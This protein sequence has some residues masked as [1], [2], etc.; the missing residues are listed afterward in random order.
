MTENHFARLWA[1]GYRRLVPIV[2]VDA[3]LSE[4]SSLYRRLN[5]KNPTDERGKAPG[6]RWPDG[7]WS[8][9]DFVKC[10]SDE[11]DIERWAAMGAGV[12]IKTGAGLALIDADTLDEK[13]AKT[14]LE[15]IKTRCGDLPVRVGRY[16]KAGYLVRTDE[17][18]RYCRI[19]FG[20]RDEKGRLKD[21]VEILSDGRQF[22]AHGIHPVTRK[23]YRW[24]KG[25]PAL[26][27]VPFVPAATLHALL[28]D[29]AS[30]L[31]SAS[32]MREEGAATDVNQAALRGEWDLIVK[33]VE[34][35][36][37]TSDLFPTRDAW[38]DYGYAIKAAAGPDRE[39]DALA[40]F[41]DWSEKWSDGE[42]DPEY[43]AAEFGRF[44]APFKRGVGWLCEL[45]TEHGQGFSSAER[46]F[47][48]VS[49][50]P[51]LFPEGAPNA[52]GKSGKRFTFEDFY[53]AADAALAQSSRPL[54]KGLLDHGAMSVVYGQSN[55]GKT[56]VVMD[57]AYCIAAALPYAGMKTDP[58]LVV[59]VSA[60]GGNNIKKRMAALCVKHGRSANV[61]LRL[62]NSSIDLRRPDADLRP[63][64]ESIRAL[65]EPVALIVIDTLSRAM[66]G[67]DENSPVDMGLI[68]RHF[69]ALRTHT[70]AHLMVVHHSGKNQAAGARGHSILKAAVDTE[71][72]V[73]EGEIEVTKQRDLDKAW[74]TGF[75][76]DVHVLG[77]DGDGD[78]VTSCTVRMVRRE[79]AQV[80]KA[81]EKERA[82]GA[83]LRTLQGLSEDAG[84][85]VSVPE[86]VAYLG[87][88]ADNMSAS[89]VRTLLSGMLRKGLVQIVRR[90]RYLSVCEDLSGRLSGTIFD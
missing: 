57:L 69:D 46:W 34:A 67:G 26:D 62:L 16:P 5:A 60:E 35:T 45:A 59:Y 84:E 39:A 49:D 85:G 40:L 80:A 43:V 24:P 31:P 32:P 22:V 30:V 73:S 13:H 58:G 41:Q 61:R 88:K 68:V 29:L 25:V 53:P 63:L 15:A 76:L 10:E 27:D 87:P 72:E 9:F 20:E 66:A 89:N 74:S 3:P 78:P 77:V 44:K 86:L 56:F 82:V 36:P 37:N 1:L 79:A 4:K 23:P 42:N 18:F 19:E 48:P 12:G 81:T 64:V 51:P 21:R 2:P 50:E 17:D 54:V 7:T 83:A 33:A 8:G 71:I 75:A 55:V 11:L 6:I 70:S 90:G 38:R 14:V 47:E 65:G 52:F 28:A